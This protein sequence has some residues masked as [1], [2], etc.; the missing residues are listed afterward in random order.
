LDAK[1]DATALGGIKL[2]WSSDRPSCR[3]PRIHIV[4][5]FHSPHVFMLLD[6]PAYPNFGMIFLVDEDHIKG[7]SFK[8]SP[9]NGG[10]IF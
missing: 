9:K 8:G 2:R 7:E 10:K 5:D 6:C 4:I 1:E 3:P